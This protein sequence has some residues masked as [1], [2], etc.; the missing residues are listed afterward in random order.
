M[1]QRID[2]TENRMPSGLIQLSLPAPP[3]LETALGYDGCARHV[4]FYWSAAAEELAWDDGK[5]SVI[6][7]NWSA[8]TSFIRHPVIAHIVANFRLGSTEI[9]AEHM[10]LVDR[11]RRSLHIGT[12]EVATATLAAQWKG[13]TLPWAGNGYG[14]RTTRGTV[15]NRNSEDNHFA[16]EVFTVTAKMQA[17]LQAVAELQLWMDRELT[18]KKRVFWLHVLPGGRSGR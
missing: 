17:E 9:Q 8:W 2:G 5:S 18:S 15:S 16:P 4:G 1:G 14:T 7:A 13:A 3:S 11:K 6:G 10:L 12:T